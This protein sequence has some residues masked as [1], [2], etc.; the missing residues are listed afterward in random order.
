MAGFFTGGGATLTF[1]DTRD[2]NSFPQYGNRWRG[3][4]IVDIGDVMPQTDMKTKEPIVR[5]GR[6]AEQLPVTLLCDG[7]GPAAER[8]LR[9]DERNPN[10]RTDTGRRVVYIKGSLRFAVGDALRAVQA[11]DLELGGYLFMFWR[12][13]GK[14][15]NSDF[16]GRLWDVHYI[17]PSGAFLQQTT[18][19]ANPAIGAMPVQQN[20][21]GQFAPQHSGFAST[22]TPATAPPPQQGW[23]PAQ[24]A[25]VTPPNPYGYRHNP[26]QSP[27][28]Q[29]Q[30]Q[31][32]AQ[33][34]QPQWQPGDAQHAPVSTYPPAPPQTPATGPETAAPAS[35]PWGAAPEQGAAP[36]A[37]YG[38]PAPPQGS[39]QPGAP[40]AGNPWQQ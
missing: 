16:I 36:Q 31:W 13:M 19:V 27:G 26:P 3:G 5:N 29:A 33:N 2:P 28:G 7:S 37:P 21:Q 40:T 17:K 9:T 20:A 32:A 38:P 23:A 24:S 18:N 1:G 11:E 35:N 15:G 8:G 34:E 12:G 6:V 25:S 14:T 22:Q 30:Q 4:Q 39:P 10:D